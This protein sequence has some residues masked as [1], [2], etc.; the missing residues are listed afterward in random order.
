MQ[1]VTSGKTTTSSSV[2]CND[3]ECKKNKQE[4][5]IIMPRRGADCQGKGEEVL[6]A[7]TQPTTKYY[8]ASD[9]EVLPA[10][11]QA[12]TN[13]YAASDDEV[14]PAQKQATTNY[15]AASK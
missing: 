11:M 8:A 4:G 13:Y 1:Q 2:V 7:Q 9:D 12:T 10:K 5:I 6:P 14:L 3:F 15:Y